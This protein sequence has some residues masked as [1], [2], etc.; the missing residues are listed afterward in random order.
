M[1]A[2]APKWGSEDNFFCTLWIQ[3]TK[4][5]ASVQAATA[6]NTEP[7]HPPVRLLSWSA[8]AGK[9]LHSWVA[10]EKKPGYLTNI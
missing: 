3:A 4:S 5:S 2:T 10:K 6:L 7:P 9:V 1:R 8:K